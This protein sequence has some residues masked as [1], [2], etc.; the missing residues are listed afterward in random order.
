MAK[1]EDIHMA[2]TERIHLD[3]D[4]NKLL[5]GLSLGDE[6]IVTVKGKV[7]SMSSP[8]NNDFDDDPKVFPGDVSVEVKERTIKKT[9]SEFSDLDESED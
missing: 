8:R 2:R 5:G 4:D 6:V 7:T 3:V 1:P 9:S